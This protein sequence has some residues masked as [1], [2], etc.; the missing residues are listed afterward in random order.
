[1]A[2]LAEFLAL[3]QEAAFG[4]YLALGTTRLPDGS[5]FHGVM[6]HKLR[7]HKQPGRIWTLAELV[8]PGRCVFYERGRCRIYPV[9]PFEC[10]R[11]LHTR[12]QQAIPLRHYIVERWTLDLLKPYLTWARRPYGRRPAGS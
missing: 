4:R 7:D 3:S 2:A 1:M 10:S 8:R 9:R 12:P 5:R 11:M 6:P